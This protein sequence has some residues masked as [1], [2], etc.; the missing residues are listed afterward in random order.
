MS[1]EKCSDEEQETFIRLSVFE[2][3]FSKDAARIVVE[4]DPLDTNDILQKLARSLIKEPTKHRYSIHLLIKHFLKDKQE[5]GDEK[6]ERALAQAMRAQVF[7][8]KYYLKLAH[9]LHEK[10]FQRRLQR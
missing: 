10:L 2:G 3:S 4:T 9:Q 5:G 7:M 6:S 1:Y 8:L